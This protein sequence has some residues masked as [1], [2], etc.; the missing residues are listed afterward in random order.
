MPRSGFQKP[1]HSTCCRTRRSQDSPL[2]GGKLRRPSNLKMADLHSFGDYCRGDE[3]RAGNGTWILFK[4]N[5]ANIAPQDGPRLAGSLNLAELSDPTKLLD[6]APTTGSM[7]PSPSHHDF[8][9]KPAPPLACSPTRPW[10]SSR[11]ILAVRWDE[12]PPTDDRGNSASPMPLVSRGVATVP[13]LP[14]DQGWRGYSTPSSPLM[15]A[16]GDLTERHC[17]GLNPATP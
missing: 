10:V 12:S 13:H 16:S 9:N 5:G 8:P 6:S 11:P 3:P 4:N 7:R 15:P 1:A 2:Q 17:S 14:A